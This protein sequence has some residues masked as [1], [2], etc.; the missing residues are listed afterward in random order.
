MTT[1]LAPAPQ[2][3]PA[4]AVDLSDRQVILF[5]VIGVVVLVAALVVL[6]IYN[7]PGIVP[8]STSFKDLTDAAFGTLI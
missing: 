2:L 3:A 8:A 6:A 1:T 7:P 5:A 4:E